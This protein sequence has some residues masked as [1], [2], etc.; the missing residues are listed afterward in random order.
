MDGTNDMLRHCSEEVGDVRSQCEEHEG[1][2]CEVG[3]EVTWI[4]KGR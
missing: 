1:T 2:D 3:R 4:N